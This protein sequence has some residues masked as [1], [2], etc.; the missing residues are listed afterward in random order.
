LVV[1]Q[2][3][4]FPGLTR[5]AAIPAE[6]LGE[7]QRRLVN[8]PEGLCEAPAGCILVH[9]VS[10]LEISA[11]RI[12]EQIGAGTSPRYLLPEA[13]LDYIQTNGIYK[14]ANGT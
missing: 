1:A 4:G 10:A 12:R 6:L 5:T 3:P 11:T 7:L 9:P 8:E 2:R 13:V 14:E